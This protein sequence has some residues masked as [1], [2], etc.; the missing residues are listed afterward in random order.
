MKFLID[1]AIS[2]KIAGVLRAKDIDAVHVRE[3]GIQDAVDTVIFERAESEKRI[4]VSA[5]TDFAYIL[6]SRRAK[7]PSVILFR[8][9]ATE[10]R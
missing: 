9:D 8:G 6:A 4:I 10:A 3:Y 1:N 7:Q 5:D 2:P